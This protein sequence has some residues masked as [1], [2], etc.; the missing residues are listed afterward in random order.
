M[1]NLTMRRHNLPVPYVPLIKFP[2]A[3]ELAVTLVHQGNLLK[4]VA[5]VARGALQANT[6][7]EL[8][9]RV[10]IARRGPLAELL[11]VFAMPAQV[12]D[13]LRRVP[14]TA[15]ML[16][17]LANGSRRLAHCAMDI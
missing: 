8:Q 11:R 6:K 16:L 13:L 9:A 14:K 4:R 3:T 17:S 5:L 12:E 15:L 1:G 2:R 7:T 10:E